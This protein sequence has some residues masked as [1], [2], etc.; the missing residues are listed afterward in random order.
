MV[1]QKKTNTLEEINILKAFLRKAQQETDVSKKKILIQEIIK[2]SIE[3]F[4]NKETNEFIIKNAI[5][6][7]TLDNKN[8]DFGII[9]YNSKLNGGYQTLLGIRYKDLIVKIN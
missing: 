6:F 7:K 1:I 9:A 5:D 8:K 4:I 2:L 3:L